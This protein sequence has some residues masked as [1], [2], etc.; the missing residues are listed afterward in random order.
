MDLEP[1][2]RLFA[3][4]LSPDPNVRKTGEL[5]IRKVGRR[6][7]IWKVDYLDQYRQIAGQEGVI[8]ALLR[9][10]STEGVDLFVFDASFLCHA[11]S[12]T[13]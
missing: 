13:L 6:P 9:I 4:T 3:T 10:I 12:L 8:A 5:E 7:R 11:C 1:L 2:T